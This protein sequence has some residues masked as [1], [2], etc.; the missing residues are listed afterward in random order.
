M[1]RRMVPAAEPGAMHYYYCTICGSEV[2][3]KDLG[4][5][6][7]GWMSSEASVRRLSIDLRAST[8]QGEPECP[9]CGWDTVP[10][11]TECSCCG[12]PQWPDAER[13][14]DAE[15]KSRRPAAPA[16]SRRAA[17]RRPNLL[18]GSMAQPTPTPPQG[19]PA[20]NA[21]ANS[22]SGRLGLILIVAV[23]AALVVWLLG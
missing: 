6:S 11:A 19:L 17:V 2:S 4:C 5:P 16:A 13:E 1:E 18:P 14:D 20:P 8:W 3:R 9:G 15:S 10:G 23:V 22:S 12:C 7:C 21:P